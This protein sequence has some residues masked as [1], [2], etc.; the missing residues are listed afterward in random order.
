M[1]SPQKIRQRV[2]FW[3]RNFT[4]GCIPKRI[5]NRD[6]N[7]HGH[8]SMIHNGQ[9]VEAAQVSSSG[10]MDKW[11]VVWLYNEISFSLKKE[12]NSNTGY[13]VNEPR[14]HY[15]KWH[16]P[17]TERQILKRFHLYEIP[18]MVTFI[19]TEV[20][21]PWPGV[22]VGTGGHGEFNGSGFQF[23]KMKRVPWIGG[24]AG[25]TTIRMSLMPPNWTVVND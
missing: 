22:G 10:W 17:L 6:S 1:E 7:A 13:N 25:C 16:K 21:W 15:V 24:G 9:G 18:G 3:S 2:P 5:E 4:S 11:N 12:G 23:C 14:G 20:E 8:G 19:E